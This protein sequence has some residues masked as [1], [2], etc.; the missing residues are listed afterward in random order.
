M[1]PHLA[2]SL[3]LL[4]VGAG[5]RGKAKNAD[6]GKSHDV[7]FLYIAS[8]SLVISVPVTA[9]HPGFNE[10]VHLPVVRVIKRK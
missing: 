7:V 5:S 2:A 9:F 8:R 4:M 1:P 10:M 6:Q 3:V